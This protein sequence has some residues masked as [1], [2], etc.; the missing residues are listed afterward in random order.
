M[1]VSLSE[2]T[3]TPKVATDSLNKIEGNNLLVKF[4]GKIN[5]NKPEQIVVRDKG[6]VVVPSTF[7]T[8]GDVLKVTPKTTL[9]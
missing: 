7:V 5:V 8:E 3:A 6:G 1:S 2:D 9:N 4:D